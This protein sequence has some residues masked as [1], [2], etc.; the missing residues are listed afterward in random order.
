MKPLL[1]Q[2][3]CQQITND[4][5]L[6]LY[7]EG[8]SASIISKTYGI[9]PARISK[10]LKDSGYKSRDYR[11]CPDFIK[12]VLRVLILAGFNYSEIS[13][14]TN[15]AY[16]YIREYVS[17][18]D[19]IKEQSR[20]LFRRKANNAVPPSIPPKS[21]CSE[22]L[23]SS[24]C[25]AYIGKALGFCSLVTELNANEEQIIYLFSIINDEMIAKH[26]NLLEKYILD[27]HNSA[28]V[29][30]IGIGK[31]LGVSPVYVAGIIKKNQPHSV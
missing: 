23:L 27:E 29:P 14:K 1:N 12:R 13:K 5:I 7:Q 19:E 22:Y 28:G 21:V 4:E 20:E 16:N 31:K 9:D 15:I 6:S 8:F 24:F 2:N 10:L 18:T 3:E 17:K 30:A 25:E 26:N 11:T